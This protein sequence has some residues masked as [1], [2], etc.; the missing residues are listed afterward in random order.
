MFKPILTTTDFFDPSE[1][2]IIGRAVERAWVVV[3]DDE[4]GDPMEARSLL[5]LCVLNEARTGE[6]NHINLVNRSIVK[7][8]QQ[9][10]QVLSAQ[11]KQPR[12]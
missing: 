4:Q 3:S 6:K 11:R 2:E 5:S 10:A 1:I 9:R 8:R 12:L 7:F